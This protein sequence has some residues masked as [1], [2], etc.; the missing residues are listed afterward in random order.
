M[1]LVVSKSTTNHTCSSTLFSYLQMMKSHNLCRF[2]DNPSCMSSAHRANKQWFKSNEINPNI[3]RCGVGRPRQFRSQH[4][5]HVHMGRP[6]PA[7][8]RSLKH[9]PLKHNLNYVSYRTGIWA[10]PLAH[11]MAHK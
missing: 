7:W 6:G 3:R 10:E 1:I 5:I 8:H 11:S 2:R 4:G 9:G